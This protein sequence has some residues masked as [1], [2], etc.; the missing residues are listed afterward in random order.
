MFGDVKN[1]D[2]NFFVKKG[3]DLFKFSSG[4]FLEATKRLESGI[5]V[6]GG[7]GIAWY[8]SEPLI[9]FDTIVI[10]RVGAYCGN[11]RKISGS[12]WITDN[13]IYIKEFKEKCFNLEF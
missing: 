9:N 1:N 3:T 5:P 12:N 11:V 2:K 4:K 6:Y 7:N 10:G 13:A 8:T